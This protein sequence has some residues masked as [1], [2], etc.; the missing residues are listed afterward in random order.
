MSDPLPGVHVIGWLDDLDGYRG[1]VGVTGSSVT[2]T[3]SSP[4]LRFSRD[5]AEEF[6]RLFVRGCWVAAGQDGAP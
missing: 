2:I 1:I 4:A 3:T 6:A 5:Q